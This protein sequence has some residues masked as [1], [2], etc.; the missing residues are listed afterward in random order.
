MTRH[1]AEDQGLKT[2]VTPLGERL[3]IAG[4][5]GPWIAITAHQS[6][7]PKR[8]RPLKV[9]LPKGVV[10]A[11]SYYRNGWRMPPAGAKILL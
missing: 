9:P 11:A 7:E 8:E 1:A 10:D 2:W 6:V 4:K 3:T 5:G